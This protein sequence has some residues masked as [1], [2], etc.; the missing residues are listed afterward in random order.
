M[1]KS[2]YEDKI[3]EVAMALLDNPELAKELH[4]KLYDSYDDMNHIEQRVVDAHRCKIYGLLDK[5]AIGYMGGHGYDEE[6]ADYWEG[7]ILARQESYWD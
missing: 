7:R 6:K 3:N 4:D 2:K 5:G 1:S